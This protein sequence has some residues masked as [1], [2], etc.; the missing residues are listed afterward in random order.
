MKTKCFTRK[1]LLCEFIYYNDK[2]AFTLVNCTDVIR[3][4]SSAKKRGCTPGRFATNERDGNF[5]GAMSTFQIGEGGNK[6][7]KQNSYPFKSV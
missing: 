1:A 4:I 5:R 3:M 2:G 6:M 7:A